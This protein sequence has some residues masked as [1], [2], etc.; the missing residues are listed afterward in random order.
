MIAFAMIQVIALWSV[1]WLA[2]AFAAGA[3]LHVPHK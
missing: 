1:F 2:V 3:M